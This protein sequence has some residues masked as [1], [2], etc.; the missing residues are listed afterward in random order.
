MTDHQ[1]NEEVDNAFFY[2]AFISYSKQLKSPTFRT[3]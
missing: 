2:E 3:T 1:M